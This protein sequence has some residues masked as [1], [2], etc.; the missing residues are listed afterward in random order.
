MGM[1]YCLHV[2]RQEGEQMSDAMCA[3]LFNP[4]VGYAIVVLVRFLIRGQR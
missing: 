2:A 3:I 1:R 4:V